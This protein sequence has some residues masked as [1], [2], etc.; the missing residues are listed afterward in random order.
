[1]K[2]APVAAAL[3]AL[4]AS[5]LGQTPYFTEIFV[6]PTGTDGGLEF[7]EIA[8]PAGFD[9]TG[10]SI[11]VVE[12]D[13]PSQGVVDLILPFGSESIGPNGLL[14]WRDAATPINSGVPRVYFTGP[15]AATTLRVADF[16]PDIENGSNTYILGFGTPPSMP[17][18]IDAN[19]DGAVD[20]GVLGGFTVVDAV[21]FLDGG[22]SDFAYGASLGFVNVTGAASSANNLYRIPTCG[23]G[24][25]SWAS[26]TNPTGGGS[27]ATGFVASSNQSGYPFGPGASWTA[28][29]GRRNLCPATLSMSVASPVV[30]GV[31]ATNELTIS[32]TNGVP[33]ALY[34]TA[35]TF[36]SANGPVPPY[37]GPHAGLI[38][39]DQDLLTQ[40][41][42][43]APPYVGI[44]DG[45]G[46]MSF[47]TEPFPVL[48]MT[49]YAA[50]VLY[51]EGFSSVEGAVA[52]VDPDFSGRTAIVSIGL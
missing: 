39:S 10:Y 49:L 6:N 21:G 22:A 43:A 24:F 5:A 16:N 50:S 25:S 29:P 23:G 4:A 52:I 38:I 15:N 32:I 12:G 19:N 46:A 27:A 14:L 47:T 18:D 30:E 13:S 28:D 2:N 31:P 36:D 44:L 33:G 11:L 9:M 51:G 48:G 34:L 41:V 37:T 17:V 45:S 40:Y 7:I 8:G 3:V 26:S 20:P 42:F 1:M 35:F